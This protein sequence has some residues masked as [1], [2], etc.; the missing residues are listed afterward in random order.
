MTKETNKEGEHKK[1][2]NWK[3]NPT[4]ERGSQRDK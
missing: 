4:K 3:N 1:K 2:K